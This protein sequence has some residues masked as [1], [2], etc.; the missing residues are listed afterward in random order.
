M[1]D[2]APT[3]GCNR[4][5][6]ERLQFS[7]SPEAECQV[8]GYKRGR[9]RLVCLNIRAPS[10]TVKLKRVRNQRI[11]R[12]RRIKIHLRQVICLIAG[13]L[14]IGIVRK[15]SCSQCAGKIIIAEL[16]RTRRCCLI[17]RI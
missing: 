14:N 4:L 6:I 3:V 9:N 17:C 12:T 15:S 10:Q 16:K 8:F 2:I 11:S 5:I 7:L 13:T 1:R